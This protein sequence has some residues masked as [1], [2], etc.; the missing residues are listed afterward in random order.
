MK[1]L[2][3]LM[4]AI[5]LALLNL[6]QADPSTFTT[7][8]ELLCEPYDCAFNF[9]LTVDTYSGSCGTDFI[10]DAS[11]CS[12]DGVFCVKHDDANL[13]VEMEYGSV[14]RSFNANHATRTYHDST[15]AY[16]CQDY[17]SEI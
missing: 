16:L 1:F 5:P 10:T 4:A 7:C 8:R 11:V 2:S 12:N 14:W 13:N 17:D 6:A 9:Y 15:G 3:V